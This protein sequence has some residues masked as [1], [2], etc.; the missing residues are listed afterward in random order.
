LPIVWRVGRAGLIASWIGVALGVLAV[1]A[2]ATWVLLW[3]DSDKVAAA[4]VAVFGIVV[5]VALWR[6]GIYPD[7]TANDGGLVI[8]NPQETV[9]V[10]WEDLVDATAGFDGVTITRL[11]QPPAR[12]WAV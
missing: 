1:L 8:R 2:V 5:A 6:V 11:S 10:P 3:S 7:A 12:I 9:R 4:L